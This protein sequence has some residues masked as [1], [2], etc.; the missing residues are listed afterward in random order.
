M[1]EAALFGENL[2][3]RRSI[4]TIYGEKS[5]TLTDEFENESFRPEPLMLLYHINMGWPFLDESMKFYIPTKKVTPRNSDAEGHE[6]KY[7][8]ME[9]PIDNEPEYVFF[10]DIK[11]SP[12]G[13][14]EV[15][16]VNNN[17]KLGLKISWN[18]EFLPHFIQWKS[19][20]SGDYVVGLEPANS[21]V[22]GRKWYEEQNRIHKLDPFAKEKNIIVFTI[23]DGESEINSAVNA[24]NQKF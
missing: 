2:V 10:H 16:A 22:N 23:L 13:N 5:F 7:N 17:L 18:T 20:A 14:T 21:L 11:A 12:Q 6:D 15:I 24:F 1:R 8:V 9:A 3:L 4:E 19:L